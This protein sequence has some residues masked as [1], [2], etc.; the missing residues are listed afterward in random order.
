MK[1]RSHGNRYTNLKMASCSAYTGDG[2]LPARLLAVDAALN[3]ITGWDLT[4]GPGCD[5]GWFAAAALDRGTMLWVAGN[6]AEETHTTKG[7]DRDPRLARVAGTAVG[8]EQRRL[9]DH[10]PG[11]TSPRHIGRGNH[12]TGMPASD[13]AV[14]ASASLRPR[15]SGIS[16]AADAPA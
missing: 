13:K 5:I 16:T 4:Q 11:H 10:D 12:A 6:F 3:P 7:T 2:T 15:T 14:R 1:Q 9:P 8:P